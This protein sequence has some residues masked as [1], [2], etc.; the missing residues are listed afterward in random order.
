MGGNKP[1]SRKNRNTILRR[2]LLIAGLAV[3]LL[4]DVALVAFALTAQKPST[5][6]GTV[7]EPLETNPPIAE[8]APTEQPAV[9]PVEAQ[10]ITSMPPTRILTA[11]DGST[12]WR[13]TTAAC[14]AAAATPELS[15]DAG[16]TWTARDA[17]EDTNSSSI[18]SI[19]VDSE[20]EASMVALTAADCAPQRVSTFVGGEQWQEYPDRVGANWYVDPVDRAT[21]HSPAGSFAAPCSAVIALAPRTDAIAAVLC[22]DGTLFR[23]GDGAATFG[24]GVALPGAA[25]LAA[26]DDGYLIVATDQDGCAG[27]QLLATS[28]EPDAVLSPNGCREVAVTP[29]ELAVASADGI[30]WLWAGDVMSR[31]TNGGSIWQ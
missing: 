30:V 24:P 22:S 18:L 9:E 17:S 13:A 25:N 3:F 19:Y 20:T 28:D 10:A 1:K 5:N 11:L 4:F 12:L 21:V 14:P 15:T 29:G 8:P 23:T 7:V 6:A 31:S 16:D 27:A 2:R 26:T